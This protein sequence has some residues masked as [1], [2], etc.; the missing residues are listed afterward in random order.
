MVGLLL[1]KFSLKG[2]VV[3]QFRGDLRIM[4]AW[5]NVAWLLDSLKLVKSILVQPK[6]RTQE[7]ERTDGRLT[8]PTRPRTLLGLA[9]PWPHG[10]SH[11]ICCFAVSQNHVSCY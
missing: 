6:T 3:K 10:S 8:L 5:I 1:P 2:F 11:A 9:F 7:T 4:V